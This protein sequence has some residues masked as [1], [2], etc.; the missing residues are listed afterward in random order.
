[1][2]TLPIKNLSSSP[3]TQ[4]GK[5]YYIATLSNMPFIIVFIYINNLY[6]NY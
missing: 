1:M 5:P 3:G 2:I 4:V 6:V